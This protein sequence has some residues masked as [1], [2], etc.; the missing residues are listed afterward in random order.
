MNVEDEYGAYQ[1]ALILGY[2]NPSNSFAERA[3]F[4]CKMTLR[5]LDMKRR[6]VFSW[7]LLRLLRMTL[8]RVLFLVAVLMISGLVWQRMGW[9]EGQPIHLPWSHL[10]RMNH[11]RAG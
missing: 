1:T 5:S 9:R 2:L 4:L 7:I 10:N 6:D 11:H 8:L 3:R